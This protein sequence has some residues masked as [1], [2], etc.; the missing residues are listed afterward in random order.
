M[1]KDY[2]RFET[3]AKRLYN[4]ILRECPEGTAKEVA[5]AHVEEAL[6]AVK[7]SFEEKKPIK[8]TRKTT[9]KTK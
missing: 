9:K 4:K 6:K 2:R 5:L 1:M 7:D 3:E 8:K